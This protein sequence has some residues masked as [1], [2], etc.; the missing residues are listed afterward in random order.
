MANSVKR[1]RDGKTWTTGGELQDINEYIQWLK[2]AGA[3][4]KEQKRRKGSFKIVGDTSRLGSYEG[5]G[6]DS[7]LP[8]AFRT[9]EARQ[10]VYA[11]KA[12]DFLAKVEE[13]QKKQKKQKKQKD[14]STLESMLRSANGYGMGAGAAGGTVQSA[15]T[16][17]SGRKSG[18]YTVSGGGL[19]N[20]GSGLKYRKSFRDT[21]SYGG[22]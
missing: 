17:Q 1:S 6:R 16:P 13:N 15:F 19:T 22:D 14:K 3:P 2:T 21:Y 12:R 4:E 9:E 7:S 11:A 5:I 18:T 10:A 8:A 20:R